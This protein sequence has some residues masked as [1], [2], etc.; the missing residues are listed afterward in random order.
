MC[1]SA[2]EIAKWFLFTVDRES[3]DSITHLK[4]Q[5]LLYYAQAWS[6]VLLKKP[7]FKEEIQAWMHGPVVPEVYEEYSKYGYKE[8]PQPNECPNITREFEEVLEDVVETYGIYQ[9]KYLEALTHSERPW[10]E[11]RG[12]LPLEARC[13]RPISLKTMEEYYTLMQ[14]S[15]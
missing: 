10:I 8:I 9:A 3:G 11:A 14:V 2:K 12:E 13:E 6:L 5:K 7:M 4:L 1:Y 15:N